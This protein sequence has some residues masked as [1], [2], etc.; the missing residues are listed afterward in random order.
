MSITSSQILIC[1]TNSSTLLKSFH[2]FTLSLWK[3]YSVVLRWVFIAVWIR[4]GTYILFLQMPKIVPFSCY[5]DA[6]WLTST[7]IAWLMNTDKLMIHSFV[8]SSNEFSTKWK[9]AFYF[10]M[11]SFVLDSICYQLQCMPQTMHHKLM[12]GLS[13]YLC[14]HAFLLQL[15]VEMSEFIS[16]PHRLLL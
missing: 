11:S 4:T 5:I 12:C 15:L 14:C 16:Q 6:C 7:I 10:C 2:S 8:V 9:F 1:K 3:Q 13:S